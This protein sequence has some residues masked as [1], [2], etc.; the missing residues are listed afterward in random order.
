M[1]YLQSAR[2]C[3]EYESSSWSPWIS[4]SNMNRLQRIQNQALRSITRLA[5][6]CQTDFLHLEAGIEPLRDRFEKIDDIIYNKYARHPP[7]DSRRQL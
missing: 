6:T 4:D 1:L 3:L 7:S 2:T 5:K